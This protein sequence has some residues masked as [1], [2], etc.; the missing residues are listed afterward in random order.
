MITKRLTFFISLLLLVLVSLPREVQASH[1][2][3]VDL[4][5]QCLNNCTIRVFLR[6]YRDCTGAVGITNNVVFNAQTP[7]CGQP[8]A[9]TAWSPQQTTEVTPLC[10]GAQTGCTNPNAT[11]NGVQ[12]YFWFRDYDICNVPNCIYTLTWGT[13][14][15]NA[16]ITSGAGS[17]GI[18]IGSTTL[19]TNI[20]P[21]NSSP[22]FANP[23]VPYICQGQP[24]TFNQGANDPEG[25]SLAYSLG[26]CLSSGTTNT[27]V[28]YGAGYSPTQP[29]G[30]SWN[31]TMNPL[32]GDINVIP[33]PGNIVVGVMCV[34]VEE[35]RNGQLINTIVRDI[36]MTVIPCPNNNLP[37]V[38]NL[39]NVQNG[40]ANGFVVNTCLGNNLCFDLV[41][42]DPDTGQI[43]T[44]FWD[45][46]ITGG[47]F[48]QTGNPSV[49]DT[50]TGTAGNPPSATFCF[51]PT[52]NGVYSFLVTLQDNACP[53]LGQ[54]QFT[55]QIVVGNLST[56]VLSANP[57][58]GT[59]TLCANP[60]GGSPPFTY[61]WTG[62]GGLSNNPQAGDSCIT[63]TYPT[64]GT[65]SYSLTI[66]DTFGC[67][68][69]DTGSVS[70]FVNVA[71]D[72]GP[73]PNFCSG[74]NATIGTPALPNYAYQWA[75]TTGLGS[76]TSA[77]TTVT[78]VNTGTAP[79]VQTYIITATDLGSTCT[80]T[81]TV[82]VTI[83]PQMN[84]TAAN[85]SVS[86]FGGTDGEASVAVNSGGVAPFTYQW[87]PGTGN[88]TTST[89]TGLVAG[90][91]T[92]TVT[93]SA[94]C[95]DII[96]TTI[97]EPSVVEVT[98]SGTPVSCFNGSDGTATAT[99]I[100]GV[101]GYTFTW[102][103]GNLTG[104]TVQNLSAGAYVV[105]A[106]DGNGCTATASVTIVQPTEVTLATQS[107][108]ST[109]ALPN[110]NGTASVIATGGTP[111]YTYLWNDLGAQTTATATGLAPGQY[112][113]T[114]TDN[115]G[116]S[117]IASVAVGD[118]PPPTVTAGPAASFCEG[119]G[120]AQITASG[121]GGTPGYSYTW[122]CQSANCGLSNPFL[123]NPIANPTAS[124]FYYVFVTD[125]NGCTSEL[126]SVFVE[127]LPKPIVDAGP[128][129]F[130]CG[131][132]APC[133]V[134]NPVIVNQSQVPGPYTYA[135]TPSSGILDTTSQTVCPRPDTTTVYTVVVTAGNGCTSELTTVDTLST[136]VVHVNPTP[137][138]EAGPEQD[139]CA[140]DSVQLQ[141]F[142]TDA[143]PNYTYQWTPA[144]GLSNNTIANPNASPALTTIYTLVVESNNCFG[145]DS[146]TVNVRT[147][148]TVD[149]GPDREICLGEETLLDAQAG[150]DS[151]ATYSFLWTPAATLSDSS[152]EDPIASPIT[153]T[154]YYVTTTSNYGCESPIDS[155][156]V[157]LKPTPIAEA[158][159]NPTICLGND[160][161]L[162]GSYYYTTTDSA[163][164]A[165]IFY[166]WSPDTDLT[167]P[168]IQDPVVTPTSSGWYYFT[169]RTNTCSTTDSV[170]LTVIPEIGVA[171]AADTTVTCS[172]D[173]VTLTATAGL[174]G[175]QFTWVPT[176]GIADPTA[177]VTMALPNGTT[178]YSVVASEGGC[179][180]TAGITITV[181]P[182]PEMGY[183]SSLEQGCAPHE[184][185]FMQAT[186]GAI[187]YTWN[188]GDGT[189]VS[190]EES[191]THIYDA[192]GSYNV[193]LTAVN[194][195][196]CD[197]TIN[198]ITVVVADP[199]TADFVTNPSFPVE[200]SLPN[201]MVNF[202]DQSQ[203]AVTY[204]WN[205]GDGF[206]SNEMNPD[207]QYTTPGEY[208]VTL[209]VTNALGC[210]SEVMHGPFVIFT[211]ELFI[212]NV[213][214]PN[215]DDIN[216]RFLVGYT[217]S[218]PFNLQVYDRW[219]VMMY[220][221]NNKTIGWDGRD[222]DG[223]AVA[224]GV[225]Y[226]HVKIGEKAYA[227]DLTLVR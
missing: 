39:T 168:T 147:I 179:A 36:Q 224:A 195:G 169:V 154:M 37:V 1:V 214:S 41:T 100:G 194:P 55:I 30:T 115:N 60:T 16:A 174:G 227:G 94:G 170:L 203:E 226:Y 153:T 64:T 161:Q 66:T 96:S 149:A 204:R 22:Q 106:T 111:G 184:M 221:G 208:M 212:P 156:L 125:T 93:D 127:V 87:D 139:I 46:G 20:Q 130:L 101:G 63:H 51:T 207:H 117:A 21:C 181:L 112:E 133:Q 171:V 183:L 69:E 81:D 5:Y 225:Y 152:A 151:T 215:D 91:Y 148:P 132:Q 32:T 50:I 122:S 206:I 123:A 99:A 107:T 26:P 2:M 59:V 79:L 105:T 131:G 178:T 43:V 140:G 189:P 10:P 167:D 35:W 155:V 80:S 83:W 6:A 213:F 23:P 176:T 158:G 129:V 193:S 28:T 57:G 145:S 126:D 62:S 42:A 71:A 160:Y 138:A 209:T 73:N 118:I 48:T 190:N 12:E 61:Q 25:D 186:D 7:G 197:A 58:C 108:P 103:P 109:C 188:F 218:Q 19:N 116:C 201:T 49:T 173:S 159:D 85:V 163:D 89:A 76:P 150:G 74:G 53:I 14:C 40:F 70:V 137:V 191:P 56:S 86:C 82:E 199:A 223:Q 192:P 124:Q 162:Q 65:Y 90:T 219:G 72:A 136:V 77:V 182:R 3:G 38:A 113:V 146:V 121:S 31:V 54:N 8:T 34:Y 187:F 198:D 33:Q 102:Q 220:E 114:V 135:W 88:Q 165:S 196:G 185:S 29:L 222:T 175:A 143:G 97:N 4:T 217:G 44:I 95:T 202:T 134:I 200:M 166:N 205:F 110:D 78:G 172:G 68:A 18:G 104:Q 9:V 27:Q 92:V 52:A 45:Q 98:A 67:V 47:T 17:Q 142:G 211:P 180:D 164:I 119:E 144:A 11:I 75:P 141:G 15:R 177:P 210:I 128:D 216:D 84:L 157:K 120:G 13:C 24:Y